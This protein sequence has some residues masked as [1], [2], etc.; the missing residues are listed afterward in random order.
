MVYP[1]SDDIIPI[2]IKIWAQ[3]V[4]EGSIS[5]GP[6][7]E[8]MPVDPNRGAVADS[9]K[10]Y[11]IPVCSHTVNLSIG[12]GTHTSIHTSTRTTTRRYHEMFAV[13]AYARREK[14]RARSIGRR[15]HTLD[16]P[17]VRKR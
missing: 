1:D 12:T 15:K 11:E 16:R 9:F 2:P 5:A 6:A 4:H 17:V 7:A 10:I 8:Q 14:T 13:P 3:V